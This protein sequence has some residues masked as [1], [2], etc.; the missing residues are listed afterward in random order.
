MRIGLIGAGAV[1]NF[2]VTA[3]QATNRADITAVCDIDS[4]RAAR[5]AAK[6]PGA[7]VFTDYREMYA[8]GAVD[9]V[10]VNTPHALHLPMVSDAAA[11]GLHVLVEKPMA[12]TLDDCD[13]MLSACAES[14]VALAVGHIQHFMPDKIAAREIVDSGELGNVVMV[15][16]YR[17]TDYRPGNRAGWF[18]S[19]EIAGGGAMINI[20]GHCLDRALWFGG[21]DVDQLFASVTNRF[22]S[23]VETDG[24]IALK[25]DNGVGVSINVVS[26]PP[27]KAD[28]LMIVCERGSIVA[29]PRA[30]T[31][32]Q[33]D[34]HTRQAYAPTADDIQTAFTAQMADFLD[35]VEGQKPTVP[36]D[37]ARRVVELVLAAY[38]SSET[39]ET[40]KFDRAV[41]SEATGR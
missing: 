33:V 19:P 16:D 14:G 17:S 24:T 13:S 34:G 2:H 8:S 28:S 10:V 39:H 15:R 12:T 9:A 3:A 30:G 6:A 21:G 32:V 7:R 5:V 38:R 25:L 35:V 18:F 22:G 27:L 37:H 23:A 11:A 20:G 4:S 1:A 26:D 40:I 31:H 29:D 36:L 41:M